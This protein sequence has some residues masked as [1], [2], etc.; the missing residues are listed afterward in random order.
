MMRVMAALAM[1]LIAA[2]AGWAQ[3]DRPAELAEGDRAAIREVIRRQLEA[4][5]RDDGGA[6]FAYASPKIQQQFGT[7]EAFMHMVRHGYPQVYRAREADFR[8][9]AM[10]G[11]QPTQAVLVVGPDGSTAMALYRMQRQPDG[12]WR[13]DGCVLVRTGEA[14]T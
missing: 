5:R 2:G 10:A 9:L 7:A 11:D 6:A 13:I 12:N 8:E 3:A 4:F 14:A 1:W